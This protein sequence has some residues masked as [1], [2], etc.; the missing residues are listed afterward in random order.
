[1]KFDPW[2][3][4]K[5]RGRCMVVVATE[6]CILHL[7]PQRNRLVFGFLC[8]TIEQSKDDVMS[9]WGSEL[10]FLTFTSLL[11][12]NVPS[13]DAPKSAPLDKSGIL[14]K[15]GVL[16]GGIGMIQR[17]CALFGDEEERRTER[18]IRTKGVCVFRFLTNYCI[19][20]CSLIYSGRRRRR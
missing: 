14:D 1:M 11:K 18:D 13:I 6:A 16:L 2:V 15:Q 3:Y 5:P 17:I 8:G 19:P 20:D 10:L 7:G 9:L 4:K 12:K